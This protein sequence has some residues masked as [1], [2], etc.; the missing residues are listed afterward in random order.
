M[1]LRDGWAKL[2]PVGEA[3]LTQPTQL[4]H[5]FTQSSRTHVFLTNYP[6]SGVGGKRREYQLLIRSAALGVVNLGVALYYE[7]D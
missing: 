3:V 7:P 5:T 2:E 6:W 4:L 1:E